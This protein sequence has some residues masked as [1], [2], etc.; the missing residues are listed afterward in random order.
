[1][2]SGGHQPIAQPSRVAPGLARGGGK[3][4]GLAFLVGALGLEPIEIGPARRRS[5]SGERAK[6]AEAENQKPI[7]HGASFRGRGWV[8]GAPPAQNRH[9]R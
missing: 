4:L 6:R 8:G 5:L 7:P 9:A 3:V 2:N 1:L